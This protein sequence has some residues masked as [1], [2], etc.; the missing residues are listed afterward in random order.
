MI[1]TAAT[2]TRKHGRDKKL[3]IMVA[4]MVRTLRKNK[5]I[6]PAILRYCPSSAAGFLMPAYP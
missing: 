2:P 1:E 6:T 5:Y 4:A 3:T